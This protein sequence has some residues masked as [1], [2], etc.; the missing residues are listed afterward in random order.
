MGRAAFSSQMRLHADNPD[1]LTNVR[2][3]RV[4]WSTPA[5]DVPT[6]FVSSIWDSE[7]FYE[8]L[9]ELRASRVWWPGYPPL[10]IP[11]GEPGRCGSES[12]WLNGLSTADTPPATD[13]VSGQGICC[14]P[15]VAIKYPATLTG[16]ESQLSW[17]PAPVITGVFQLFQPNFPTLA[18]QAAIV[19]GCDALFNPGYIGYAGEVYDAVA[20]YNLPI[21]GTPI[22][23]SAADSVVEASH[24]A[25]AASVVGCDAKASQVYQSFPGVVS[26][27]LPHER[28]RMTG[29][30]AITTAAAATIKVQATP[31]P[32]IV[33]GVAVTF[34]RIGV[35]ENV[36]ACTADMHVQEQ[37][38]AGL[39][40]AALFRII[41]DGTN[42]NRHEVPKLILG[43]VS[44]INV[45]N[46]GPDAIVTGPN[47]ALNLS[48]VGYATA[49]EL[50][51]A[52]SGVVFQEV[53]NSAIVSGVS[54]PVII[55]CNATSGVVT[56]TDAKGVWPYRVTDPIVTGVAS[57]CMQHYLSFGGEVLAVE[58][59]SP[60]QKRGLGVEIVG[61][62]STVKIGIKTLWCPDL[63]PEVMHLNVPSA[64]MG[65]APLQGASCILTW[66]PLANGWVGTLTDGVDSGTV[67]LDND[68][69][70]NLPKVNI[71][72][73][74]I[75]IQGGA[76]NLCTPNFYV[77]YSGMCTVGG[78]M[79]MM[80][81]QVT[82]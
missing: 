15:V 81:V 46:L 66:Q 21:Q 78:F 68:V 53:G 34:G 70:M 29:F 82:G 14:G 4:P 31:T 40:T 23:L 44:E 48:F 73:G 61:A 38:P 74:I 51:S 65:A 54:A 9:G 67:T 39:V 11:L 8:G 50:L 49:S 16:C 35:V 59:I 7:P 52:D 27:V 80:S 13:G 75:F 3:F 71:A 69:F 72:G 24:F 57:T 17:Q 18:T 55:H 42:L 41:F 26:G 76:A 6:P 19:A 63:L 77:S 62:V 10:V 1:R 56:N 33:Y 30:A 47:V 20:T 36:S 79:G 32:A 5:L 12:Q 22:T 45:T 60:Y 37:T 58:S 2:W 43:C 25:S 64:M 28:P